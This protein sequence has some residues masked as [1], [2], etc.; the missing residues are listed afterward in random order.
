MHRKT[1]ASRY[2]Y[3]GRVNRKPRFLVSETASIAF[4]ARTKPHVG[5]ISAQITGRGSIGMEV[6]SEM[7]SHHFLRLG[8]RQGWGGAETPFHISEEALRRHVYVVGKTGT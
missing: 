5:S 4:P 3:S 2:N 8:V 7:S 6:A 1:S